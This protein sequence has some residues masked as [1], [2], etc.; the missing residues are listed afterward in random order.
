MSEQMART[1]GTILRVWKR[2]PGPPFSPMTCFMPSL[3]GISQSF[4][5]RFIRSTA[6]ESTTKSASVRAS[7]LWEVHSTSTSEPVS[8]TIL[9]AREPISSSLPSSMSWRTRLEPWR[10]SMLQASRTE[11]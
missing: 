6:M 8:P 2:P 5:H 10:A 9:A 11:L 4:L 1:G 7:S 3:K